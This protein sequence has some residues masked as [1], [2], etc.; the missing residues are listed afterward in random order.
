M[1]QHSVAV[2]LSRETPWYVK[3]ILG[4]GMLYIISPYDIIPEWTPVIGIVDD[5]ALAAI[6]EGTAVAGG[7]SESSLRV[8]IDRV[9][10]AEQISPPD[11]PQNPINYHWIPLFDTIGGRGQIVKQKNAEFS[12]W[13]VT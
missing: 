11:T 6:L 4:T 9:T 1:I 5:L 10:T 3:L 2:F 8:Q 12:F 7:E 13:A